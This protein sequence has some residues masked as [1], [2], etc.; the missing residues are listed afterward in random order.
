MKII[1]VDNFDRENVSDRLIVENL[2]EVSAK[3]ICKALQAHYGGDHSSV[4]FKVVE[5]DHKLYKFEP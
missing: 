1:A 2:D 5:N 3:Y 4:F